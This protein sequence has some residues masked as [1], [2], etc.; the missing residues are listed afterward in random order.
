MPRWREKQRRLSVPAKLDL[1]GRI[2]L[3]T[4]SLEIIKRRATRL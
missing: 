2:I 1:L 4:R 3:Q